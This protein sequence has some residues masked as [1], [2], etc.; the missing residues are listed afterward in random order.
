MQHKSIYIACA[1][2]AL[3]A[4]VS[5]LTSSAVSESYQTPAEANAEDVTY[6]EI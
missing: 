1:A 6:K 4:C 3:V 5:P 2:L